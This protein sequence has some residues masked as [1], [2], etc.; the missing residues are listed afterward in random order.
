MRKYCLLSAL[1]L[2]VALIFCLGGNAL[3]YD[4]YH[5]PIRVQ[6][7]SSTDPALSVKVTSGTY[8]V[9]NA[10]GTAT[11]TL[12]E[13]S[14]TT[15]PAGFKLSSLDGNGRFQYGSYEYRGDLIYNGGNAVNVIGM[16]QYLYG[17][18]MMEIGGYAPGLEALKAQAVAS[19]NL[20]CYRLQNPRNSAYYDIYSSTSDQAYHGYSGES[21]DTAV[22]AR[23]RAAV[24]ATKDQVMYYQ[25][26]L[27]Q[28]YYMANGGG[29]TEAA[30]I[31]W[32][33]TYPYLQGVS[34]PWDALPF[35]GDS[36][37]YKSMKMPTGYEW[38]VTLSFADLASELGYNGTISDIA[39]SRDGC[40]SG[41][42]RTMTVNGSN[43]SVSYSGSK[44]RTLLGLRSGD[45][46]IVITRSVAAYKSLSLQYVTSS[47]F[48]S[49]FST[50][51]KMVTINGRGY[52]HSVGMS[53]WSACVMAYQ[54]YNYQYILNYFYNQNQNNGYLTFGAY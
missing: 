25:G 35:V 21:A 30:A 10:S 53:Q 38:T 33:G 20:S 19:R 49:T 37:S 52:G 5:N 12:S 23:V 39:V 18:V 50:S 15:L 16:E 44:V 4:G 26:T 1:V 54:G 41:Y 6:L 7:A 46:D 9:V 47:S 29:H 28:A 8:T 34:C 14:S 3:A 36:G 48:A 13:G 27:V 32:G 2:I 24:D 11:A 45:F 42:V 17:V 22:G 51:G 40:V 31:V 43:G